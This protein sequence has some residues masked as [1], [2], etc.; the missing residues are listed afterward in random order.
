MLIG[1]SLIEENDFVIGLEIFKDV[2]ES[3]IAHIAKELHDERLPKLG[4]QDP[5]LIPMKI[6]NHNLY[7]SPPL[8][9]IADIIKGL[10]D[11]DQQEDGIIQLHHLDLRHSFALKQSMK[12]QK[13]AIDQLKRLYK[14][15]GIYD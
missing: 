3:K 10:T 15:K 11:H 9:Q 8:N 7:A 13:D 14:E 6:Q 1:I 5:R 4:P 12:N 2:S